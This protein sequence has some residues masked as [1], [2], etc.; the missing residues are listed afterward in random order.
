MIDIENDIDRSAISSITSAF[1]VMMMM[2]V[3][4]VLLSQRVHTPDAAHLTQS[5]LKELASDDKDKD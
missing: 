3:C 1:M 4:K 5:A 2:T